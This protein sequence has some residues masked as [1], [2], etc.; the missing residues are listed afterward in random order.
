MSL[1]FPLE[2]DP[3]SA[4]RKPRQ[5]TLACT[6]CGTSIEPRPRRKYCAACGDIVRQENKN[7]RRRLNRDDQALPE[8]RRVGYEFNREMREIEERLIGAGMTGAELHFAKVSEYEKRHRNDPSFR[9]RQAE[10]LKV[11]LTSAPA[12]PFRRVLEQIRDGHNDPRALARMAL[13]TNDRG[14]PNK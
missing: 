7:N 3:G 6:R 14:E 13:E 8:H 1:N 11:V 9:E 12:D 2:V 4:K 10:W 5:K